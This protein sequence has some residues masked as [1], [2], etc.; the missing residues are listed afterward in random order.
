VSN[1]VPI[2]CASCSRVLRIPREF[3]GRRVQ[4]KYCAHLFLAQVSGGGAAEISIPSGLSWETVRPTPQRESSVE[5]P[6]GEHAAE[7][8]SLRAEL[9]ALDEE[10]RSTQHELILAKAQVAGLESYRAKARTRKAR[11]LE[12]DAALLSSR[13]KRHEAK[14]KIARLEEENTT[15]RAEV[16]RTAELE[17]QIRANLAELQLLSE[18][19]HQAQED[20]TG[21]RLERDSALADRDRVESQLRETRST[22]ESL[23]SHRQSEHASKQSDLDSALLELALLRDERDGL[24]QELE[25]KL[26]NLSAGHG[27][28]ERLLTEREARLAEQDGAMLEERA[29]WAA[30]RAGLLDR[31]IEHE[32]AFAD[33]ESRLRAEQSERDAWEAHRTALLAEKEASHSK[34]ENDRGALE[35]KLAEYRTASEAAV[36]DR[37]ARLAE[38]QCLIAERD[39]LAAR[40]AEL[41]LFCRL[42]EDQQRAEVQ[43]ISSEQKVS[44][45]QAEGLERSI[46]RLGSDPQEYRR[47][48]ESARPSVEKHDDRTHSTTA[49]APEFAA[50]LRRGSDEPAPTAFP[51]NGTDS[52]DLADSRVRIEELTAE[53]REAR[54]KVSRLNN[55]L[56]SLGINVT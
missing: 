10:R 31:L 50:E 28:R 15:I 35:R 23:K 13:R 29:S 52:L 6:I 9:E 18:A 53:L 12:Y 49:P 38:N 51:R 42:R 34:F 41:E 43:R 5:A 1:K 8:A 7:L 26:A 24:R 11:I 21:L 46:E 19:L 3:L 4:C 2:P 25:A 33:L 56:T 14:Q 39:S 54:F 47:A 30:E 55:V 45:A 37:D 17:E 40:I 44:Q 32:G 22:H 20:G 36:T 48:V 27:E 16:G